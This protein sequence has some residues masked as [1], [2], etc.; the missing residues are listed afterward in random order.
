LGVALDRETHIR[1]K[2]VTA[3]LGVT[4][5]VFVRELIASALGTGGPPFARGW[6]E[7]Y[8]AGYASVMSR[9]TEVIAQE[10]QAMLDG[11]EDEVIGFPGPGQ[12]P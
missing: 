7:G 10:R 9:F 11:I 5:A 1:L 12:K 8:R 6:M 2:Q 3:D 4:Q